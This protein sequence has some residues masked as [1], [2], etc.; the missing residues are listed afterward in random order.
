[1]IYIQ[2]IKKRGILR[3]LVE[4]AVASKST[5]REALLGFQ[6]G[7][8]GASFRQGKVI[9]STSGNGQSASFAIGM[10][11]N[12]YTQDAVFGLSE[13]LCEILDD[14]ASNNPTLCDDATEAATRALFAAMQ[15][16]DRLQSVNRLS[17]DFTLLNWP[18]T[19]ITRGG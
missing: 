4:G 18:Q 8:N 14:T 6:A 19:G 3:Q 10:Q 7:I 11:G 9:V 17:A 13:E 2:A 12:E 15:Q 16:D 1:M 5:L